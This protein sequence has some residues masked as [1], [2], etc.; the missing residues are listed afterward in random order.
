MTPGDD[1]HE[2]GC[3]S[4]VRGGENVLRMSRMSGNREASVGGGGGGGVHMGCGLDTAVV[5]GCGGGTRDN[6]AGWR[7][8]NICSLRQH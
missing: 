2:D 7:D 6:M 4:V 3:G 1:S 8:I 5:L